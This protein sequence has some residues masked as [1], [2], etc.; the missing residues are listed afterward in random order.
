MLGAGWFL[1]GMSKINRCPQTL[2]QEGVSR[3][4]RYDAQD[5]YCMDGHKLFAV[6][7]S[8]GASGTQYRTEIDQF[9]NIRS[10][11]AGTAGPLKF[12]VKTKDGLVMEYGHTS[13]SRVE[14]E[15]SSVVRT[16]ALNKV[17]DTVGNAYHLSYVED[18]ANGR[19]YIDKITYNASVSIT[20]G[21]TGNYVHWGATD[22]E[23][24]FVY[25][26]RNDNVTQFEA[27]SRIQR[28]PVKLTNIHTKVNGTIVSDYRLTYEQVGADKRPRITQMKRCDSAGTCQAPIDLEW[29]HDGT[30][31]FTTANRSVPH[32][33]ANSTTYGSHAA[34]I[35]YDYNVP[36]WHD[37]DG[38]GIPE[39]VHAVPNS[40]GS[41][42]ASNLSLKVRTYTGTNSFTTST[43]NTALGGHPKDFH[44]VDIDGNGTTDLVKVKV[45]AG[46]MEAALSTGSGFTSG[47]SYDTFSYQAAN[48]YSL[49]DMN[50]DGLID[51]VKYFF[52]TIPEPG[53]PYINT[54]WESF[55]CDRIRTHIRT[56]VHINKGNGAGYGNGGGYHYQTEWLSNQTARTHAL[57]D[58]TGDG[59]KDLIVNDRYVYVNDG[60]RFETPRRD[61]G[62]TPGGYVPVVY[63]DIDG[64]GV[65]DRK[66]LRI[67]GS[68]CDVQ[69]NTGTAFLHWS[70]SDVFPTNTIDDNRVWDKSLRTAPGRLVRSTGPLYGTP[71]V[72][73]HSS[74]MDVGLARNGDGATYV[75]DIII[76]S[77]AHL[78]S[79]M[80]WIDLNGDGLKDLSIANNSQCKKS[81]V[82]QAQNGIFAYSYQDYYYCE[83]STHTLLTQNGKPVSL[84]KK[85][86]QG[87]GLETVFTYK[88]LTNS[89]VY[90][91]GSLASFPDF[92]IQD[93]THVVSRMTQSNGI[94]GVS[95][96]ST[97]DYTYEG[98]VRNVQGRGDMGF[99]KIISRNLTKGI[100]T[101]SEYAQQFP[102]TSQP[103]KIE[104]FR[105]S[106]N[107]L[108][109]S[110]QIDYLVRNTAISATRFP[111][112]SSRVEK[113][114][115]LNDG[116]L[117][118]TSSTTNSAV[119]AYGNI[120]NTT[121]I[122][123][124]HETTSTIQQQKLSTF[125]VDPSWA[126]WRV[127]QV[128]SVTT[129]A[130]LNGVNDPGKDR[131]VDYTYDTTTGF[132]LTETREPGKGA[133]I[134]LTKTLAHDAVGNVISETLSSPGSASR[135]S[136]IAYDGDHRFPATLTNP[137]GHTVD[138]TWDAAF[139]NK[140]SEIDVNGLTTT[141]SYNS[142][143]QLE[144][145]TR[146]DGTTTQTDLYT[147][148]SV[149]CS[150]LG[151]T[152]YVETQ[153]SGQSTVR[154]YY[155]VLGRQ[156]RMR[157]QA[158]DGT[159]VNQDTEYDAQGRAFRSS[160]P[161][162]DGGAVTW[163]TSTY[164]FLD[165]VT[166]FSGADPVASSTTSYDGFT[167][168]VTD[169]A[170]RTE[171]RT[172][173]ALGQ[174]IEVQ[175]KA[176]TDTTFLYD[177]VG[178][179]VQV[180]NA[181]GL[182]QASSVSYSYDRL[183]NLLTQNDPDHGLYTYTY[184]AF[185]NKLTEASPKLA[186]T[187]RSISYQ[188]DLLNRMISRTEPEGTTTWTYDS[189]TGGNLGVGKLASESM[190]GFSRSYDYAAGNYG[191]LTDTDT[192]I[193]TAVYSVAYS[194]DGFGRVATE[195]YPAS[196]AEPGGLVVEYEY[197]PVGMLEAVQSPGG[198]TVYYQLL[199]TDAAGRVTSE[200]LGDG[201]TVTQAYAGQSSRITSQH[202]AIG[203]TTLQEFAYTYDGSGNMLS[204]SDVR[205]S[206]T[207]AFTFDNL[208]RMTSAQVGSHPIVNYDFDAMGSMTE[209]S[210]IGN[211]YLYNATP[212]HAVSEI[213][214][215]GSS[216]HTFGYD[217]NGNMDVVDGSPMITWS[218]YNKPTQISSGGIT[219]AFDYGTDRKRYQKTR[220]GV[221]THYVG[222]SFEATDS[223]GQGADHFRHY[224]RANGKVVMIREDDNGTVSER[225]VHR[226]HLGSVTALTDDLGSVV[227]RFSYD[228]WGMRR[229]AVDWVSGATSTNEIRGYTGHEHLDDVG[230][231][232]MNGRIYS[233]SLGRMLNPD[234]VVGEPENGRNYN[235]YTYVFNNPLKYTDP[236]GFDKSKS[237][238]VCADSCVSSS[239]AGAGLG[240]EYVHVVARDLS[241]GG[242]TGN[243][244]A[245]SSAIYGQEGSPVGVTGDRVD[246]SGEASPETDP[247]G[248]EGSFDC[249]Q[250][251]GTACITIRVKQRD[252]YKLFIRALNRLADVSQIGAAAAATVCRQCRF[253]VS[254]G[255]FMLGVSV[256]TDA[257]QQDTD[258]ALKDAISG[259]LPMAVAAAGSKIPYFKYLPEPIQ[260]QIISGITTGYGI[261]ALS[262]EIS[263]EASRGK[264]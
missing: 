173:N 220:N 218:S 186:A 91:K 161:Y 126:T 205:Q 239:G 168:S 143:G 17:S 118:S 81:A 75:E 178:N 208:D 54:T 248:G 52:T 18:N 181:V 21:S 149:A 103:L 147:C 250:D 156:V 104:V 174:V 260:E 33:A 48:D 165:R 249:S 106:D 169:S 69:R 86:T 80:Q 58:V 45:G 1:S 201:S 148:T 195:T 109:E 259:G 105:A 212:Q 236:S 257:M 215:G 145:E 160:E 167:V 184:D 122:L 108:L 39:Y 256:A 42:P 140:L 28:N 51:L 111:Y 210:D 65:L 107:R 76:D 125:T 56:T 23:V 164:D 217:A 115:A 223:A 137:L 10:E 55:M 192:T 263:K 216:I 179:S 117:L 89:S 49:A 213:L 166:A 155:D 70:S 129:K 139:G 16:W 255:A 7:G 196:V 94:G 234:P 252:T 232:H 13:N 172:L 83:T 119:D 219:Y 110:T 176:G 230:I 228:A 134:E 5:V 71:P 72:P 222:G 57:F 95:T 235:R 187:G 229:R 90:T 85:I 264:D 97:V 203:V 142:F 53:C 154:T 6:S 4:V 153:A 209:K 193:G 101:V 206:L 247:V 214:S 43:W 82:G 191:R 227:E 211:P 61:F 221:A 3:P 159:R 135:T 31:T 254:A 78:G 197:S 171:T 24:K 258:A 35:G 183:G 22:T 158:L 29:W 113:R 46:T 14:G 185:G 87:Q 177:A 114:Y 131:Q 144:S 62:A 162:F 132:L 238:I 8:Y 207:E 133:G 88:P 84:L 32:F 92:D 99:A 79:F 261:A 25:G 73:T 77:D 64:D 231:I 27:G 74:T 204:R 44:W 37:M 66:V 102:Y 241:G 34:T 26:S 60:A 121:T 12:T 182:G 67:D 100:K 194:Y 68:C 202:S 246:I 170:S 15:G 151:A 188:Y 41:Y 150:N 251:S 93:A 199:D 152:S 157:T 244:A 226:D 9:S 59:L 36:R 96:V 240:M 262:I 130:W 38:D 30:T 136:T 190:T 141:W 128:S 233:P 20:S 163:N 40:N 50:G 225:Y 180:N 116:R 243:T 138:Q 112:V 146:P 242:V 198:G 189:S 2:A 120:G 200:W 224:I 19:H 98:L 47:S 245:M 11:G 175:D 63:A 123:E 253:P 237:K 127:G 124:D